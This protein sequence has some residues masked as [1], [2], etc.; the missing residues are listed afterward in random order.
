MNESH[1]HYVPPPF[2]CLFVI[3][4][5]FWWFIRSTHPDSY[6]IVIQSVGSLSMVFMGRFGVMEC[7]SRL[8]WVWR[9]LEIECGIMPEVW[10]Q[11]VNL[12]FGGIA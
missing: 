3:A 10:K 9:E 1:K 5:V 2:L 12:R 6:A 7:E 8:G 11:D 4:I